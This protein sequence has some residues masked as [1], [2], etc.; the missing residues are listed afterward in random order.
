M[1]KSPLLD[2]DQVLTRLL[3]KW[4]K[5]KPLPSSI[6]RSRKLTYSTR[7]GTDPK[8][9]LKDNGKPGPGAYNNHEKANN[10][11]VAYNPYFLIHFR[12]HPSDSRWALR[13]L[14]IRCLIRLMP[15]RCLDQACMNTRVLLE[16]CQSIALVTAIRASRTTESQAQA[17]IR[18]RKT[19]L[20]R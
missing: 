17:L 6:F 7:M 8:L 16:F 13:L 19:W 11:K 2:Q 10:V 3:Q 12:L 18:Q 20:K 14:K 4:Q 5:L 15:L 9:K 1:K